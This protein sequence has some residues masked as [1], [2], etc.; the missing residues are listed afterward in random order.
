MRILLIKPF[1]VADEIIPPIS[2]GWLATNAR[3]SHKLHDV[4]I[5]DALKEGM[6]NAAIAKTIQDLNIDIVGFQ[7]W[8]KDIHMVKSVSN[9]IKFVKPETKIIVGGIHPTMMPEET[10]RFF[11]NSIDFAYKGEGEIGF[12]IFL[13]ILSSGTEEGSFK[14]IPG[15]VWREGNHI[16]INDNKMIEDLDSLDFPAWDLIPP[17]TYPKSPH[18]AFYKNF[19]VAPIIVTRGCPF[20]C[21]FCSAQAASGGKLRSR[22]LGHVLEEL[23]MLYYKFGVREFQIE[24]DNFTINNKFV[25]NF[26]ET[27]LLKNLNMTWSFPNGIRLDTIDRQL[28]KLMKKA[29]CYAVNFG[30]ESGSARILN[31]IKKRITL[32]QI[33]SQI[34]M[35]HEEGYYTGGFF[36]LGFPTETREEMEST[37]RF[38]HS[39]PLDRVGV[40]YFQPFPGTPLFYEL[41][42][43]GEIP[44]DWA[45]YHYTT[46]HSLTY[47]PTTL[48]AKELQFMRKNMLRTFYFRPKIL[49][50]LLK[51]IKSPSHM[52]YMIKRGIRWLRA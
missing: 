2:L 28:L 36:I 15:L 44:G 31:M 16:K 51:E 24:D 49:I 20:P 22:S 18:G 19:P 1:G 37:I 45:H 13:D 12:K 46:L 6:G 30:I 3:K 48:S 42:K 17:A 14:E 41:V 32:E 43:K 8:S 10:M 38:A 21:T 7:V 50:K 27:L 5:L 26:C 35:A 9:T 40:S 23:E 47:V 34:T 33:R 4:K 39:L 52:Y 29:G 25:E 11:G